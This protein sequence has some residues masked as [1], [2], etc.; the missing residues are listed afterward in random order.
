MAATIMA[1]FL[2]VFFRREGAVIPSRGSAHAAGCDLSASRPAVVPA[3][4]RAL[5]HTDLTI[6]VP[7]GTYGRVAPRSGL[8]VRAGIAVGAGVVDADYR[9]EV[10]VLLF[11]HGEEDFV[12]S[13]GDR[14]AQLVVE[15]I[16]T[17]DIM[18]IDRL[19]EDDDTGRGEAGFGSTG[20]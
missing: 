7:D 2:R 4:G 15:R 6:I 18:V 14:V 16:L 19:A 12:V 13:P 8:A 3:G 9:G 17:P 5:V 11:N 10:C 1:D 20:V